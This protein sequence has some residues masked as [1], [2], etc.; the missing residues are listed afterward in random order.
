MKTTFFT[1]AIRS[2]VAA[3]G[4]LAA[5]VAN[6]QQPRLPRVSLN[7]PYLGDKKEH[8]LPIENHP[9][10]VVLVDSARTL[11]PME[12]IRGLRMVERLGDRLRLAVV[13]VSRDPATLGDVDS[14]LEQ[15]SLLNLGLKSSPVFTQLVDRSGRWFEELGKP[16]LPHA[17]LVSGDGEI[18]DR[19]ILL[20]GFGDEVSRVEHAIDP[21]KRRPSTP[22]P[23]DA[24]LDA[25]IKTVRDVPLL[26]VSSEFGHMR[27]ERTMRRIDAAGILKQLVSKHPDAALATIRGYGE[28]GSS[29]TLLNRFAAAALTQ[30]EASD[31][32]WAKE[33]VDSR[34][35]GTVLVNHWQLRTSVSV[36]NPSTDL[37]MWVAVNCTLES[38]WNGSQVAEL[39]Q[40]ALLGPGSDAYI[41][42]DKFESLN[43]GW[44]DYVV[45]NKVEVSMSEGEYPNNKDFP[46]LTRQ[47][48]EAITF[49]PRNESA[50]EVNLNDETRSAELIAFR[51]GLNQSLRAAAMQTTSPVA[52]AKNMLS[53]GA[54]SRVGEW[55][56][57]QSRHLTG[58]TQGVGQPF[59]NLTITSWIQGQDQ[60]ANQD[61]GVLSPPDGR[62]L[63]VDFMFVNC[64][65]CQ[66][67]L[68]ELSA[69]HE[70]FREQGLVVVSLTTSWGARGIFDLVKKKAAK[71]AVAV[72]AQNEERKYNVTSF[73]T[74]LLVDRRGKVRWSGIGELPTRDLVRTVLNEAP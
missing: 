72:L 73:P 25:I 35:E 47:W 10:I 3:L 13:F 51:D 29:Y 6:A 32:A 57:H 20:G 54:L 62:A 14:A 68:P 66:A 39:R 18:I 2:C 34:V 55:L 21:S 44:G 31:C 36:E 50:E 63:L 67:A 1:S 23:R 46:T 65:P 56:G 49:L 53:G 7:S 45:H 43:A 26:P 33:I 60:F 8:F 58:S 12:L 69:L 42:Q 52:A 28:S 41:T 38:R 74:L 24:A 48:K 17:M 64:P 4:L 37:R 15:Q 71:H 70:E 61:K 19:E 9:T 40:T 30:F 16:G 59:K 27:R 22:A 5:M 11:L